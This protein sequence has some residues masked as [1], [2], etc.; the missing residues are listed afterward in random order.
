MTLKPGDQVEWIS[1]DAV[2]GPY[3]EV[4]VKKGE[5]E[6]SSQSTPTDRSGCPAK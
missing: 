1:G 3:H 5:S 4:A 6:K 2:V